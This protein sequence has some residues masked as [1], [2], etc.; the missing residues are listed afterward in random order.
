MKQAGCTTEC[1]CIFRKASSFRPAEEG[2]ENRE[3]FFQGL[4]VRFEGFEEFEGFGGFGEFEGFG[5]FGG[6]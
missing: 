1:L 5:E 4:G 3:A 6:L 2:V